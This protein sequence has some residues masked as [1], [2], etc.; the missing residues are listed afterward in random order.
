MGFRRQY[1]LHVP[2]SYDAGSPAPLV[3]VLH[4]AF[5]TAASTADF[6]GFT[7]LA[8]RDGFVV[9]YP[10]GIGL[11]GLFQHWNAGFCCAMAQQNG[12]DD[13]GFLREA[14]AEVSERL[15]VDPARIFL[16]G[17]SNG[18]MLAFHYAAL[19]PEQVAAVATVAAS[20]GGRLIFEPRDHFV[21]ETAV[22][23]T[24]ASPAQPSFAQTSPAGTPPVPV[25]MFHGNADKTVPFYGGQSVRHSSAW[26][27]SAEESAQF[28]V[29]RNK[30]EGLPEVSFHHKDTVRRKAWTQCARGS[31]VV[32]YE[33]AGWGHYWPNKVPDGDL[34]AFEG[35]DAASVIWDFFKRHGREP[36]QTSKTGRGNVGACGRG[37]IGRLFGYLAPVSST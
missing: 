12:V 10:E 14:I 5:S 2:A 18:G 26:F 13:V 8:E 35:L 11:F 7:E 1:R 28:W 30:C 6:C 32:F 33:L 31:E 15:N 37:L 3:V 19:H 27:L 17:T 20:V 24:A 34:D 29:G 23:L 9:L 21:G 4:G 25:L 16:V 22:S 36:G